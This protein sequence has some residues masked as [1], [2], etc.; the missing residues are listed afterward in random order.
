MV[1]PTY[2]LFEVWQSHLMEAVLTHLALFSC[3]LNSALRSCCLFSTD[4][5]AALGSC[6]GFG[7]S[8]FWIIFPW[9]WY[10][11]LDPTEILTVTETQQLDMIAHIQTYIHTQILH[12]PWL[13]LHLRYAAELF[14]CDC[15]V[16]SVVFKYFHNM[17]IVRP[18]LTLLLI[19]E[20]QNNTE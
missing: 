13:T 15:K 1:A 9:S 8:R 3:L 18:V 14:Y 16:I 19:M 2:Q 4:F 7:F 5:L 17:L 6:R 11:D 12:M 20:S 10:M